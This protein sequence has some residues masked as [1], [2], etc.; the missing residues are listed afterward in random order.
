MHAALLIV[1]LSL[2]CDLPLPHQVGQP[3]WT[4]LKKLALDAEIVGPREHWLDDFRSEVGY[5]RRHWQELRHAPPLSDCS[6][7]PPYWQVVEAR[8]FSE[9]YERNFQARLRI[10]LYR[11]EELAAA[12]EE[13]RHLRETW[14]WLATATQETESWAWRRLALEHLRD[15]DPEGYY[16]GRFPPAVP[17]WRF[18]R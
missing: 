14:D 11:Q 7:L 18:E 16:A 3:W 10:E 5:V 4:A 1:L 12:I 17:V 9:V 13:N 15:R 2:P 8:R 6:L